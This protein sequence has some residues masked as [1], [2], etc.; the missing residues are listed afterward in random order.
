MTPL[1]TPI[2]WFSPGHKRSYDVASD[3]V[4][5]VDMRE[6]RELG[7]RRGWWEHPRLTQIPAKIVTARDWRERAEKG[8]VTGGEKWKG[9]IPKPQNTSYILIRQA[10]RP[11]LDSPWPLNYMK[12][13]L[14]TTFW[15]VFGP[16]KGDKIRL[17][18][19]AWNGVYECKIQ[20]QTD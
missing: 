13:H 1:T 18:K 16:E 14:Q 3:S 5:S 2:F 7:M 15:I 11:V 9:G 12:T 20:G 8:K 19:A 17:L 6:A 4:A 10:P